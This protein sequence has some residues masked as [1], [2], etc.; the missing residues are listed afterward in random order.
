MKMAVFWMLRL[1]AH[2]RS[3]VSE[4]RV[5]SIIRVTRMGELGT[6]VTVTVNRRTLRRSTVVSQN[7]DRL[8]SM[9][10]PAVYGRSS[11]A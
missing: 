6:T 1:V 10:N 11:T 5:A 7:R 2:L 9:N 8:D 3:D 4:E